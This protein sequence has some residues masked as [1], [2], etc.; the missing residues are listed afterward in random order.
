MGHASNKIRTLAL[1]STNQTA[2][3]ETFIAAHKER[4]P[5]NI[6]YYYNGTF[7]KELLGEGELQKHKHL[8]RLIKNIKYEF[9]IG[10]GTTVEEDALVKSFKKHKVDIVLAEYGTTGASVVNVC[11]KINIPLLVHFHGFDISKLAVL[12]K[13]KD[14]YEIMFSYASCIF[15]VSHFMTERL[16]NIGCPA[17]KITYNPYGPHEDFF[18]INKSNNKNTFVSIGRFTDK[19]APY[20]TILAF[21]KVQAIYPDV[22]LIIAGDG[23]LRNTCSNLINYLGIAHKVELIGIVT[24]ELWIPYLSNAFAYVQHSIT[25]ANGDMEGLP[26]AILEACAAGLP[27]VS[28]KHSG[29]A[30]IIQHR[31][32]GLLVNEHDVEDMAAQMIYLLINKE[33]AHQFGEAARRTICENFNIEKHI[34]TITSKINEA[35]G[36]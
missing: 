17:Y 19:K 23:I 12:E 4:L 24:R 32:N 6:K 27:V 11:K 18:K 7:P 15:S 31:K 16:K 33:M 1:L 2:Y 10:S 34:N 26:I 8:Y 13:Y 28:T 20:Y 22:K 36:V 29:I 3:S 25:S 9:G 21:N 30:D 14:K 35:L 5:F